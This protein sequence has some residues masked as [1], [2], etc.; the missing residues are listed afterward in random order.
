M[1]SSE[2]ALC[3]WQFIHCALEKAWVSKAWKFGPTVVLYQCDYHLFSMFGFLEGFFFFFAAACFLV[4]V[5]F[6]I[7]L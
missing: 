1:R 4:N 7:C 6:G 5:L 3:N 2:N